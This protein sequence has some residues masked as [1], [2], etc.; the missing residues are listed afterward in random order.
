[1]AHLTDSQANPDLPNANSGTPVSPQTSF[2]C[3]IVIPFALDM[4]KGKAV[5]LWIENNL[6]HN[7]CPTMEL[8]D[9]NRV[10]SPRKW[11]HPNK[12]QTTA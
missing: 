6:L 3:T 12:D 10:T 1:M 9:N 2:P 7:R 8:A 11:R 5:F 4:T